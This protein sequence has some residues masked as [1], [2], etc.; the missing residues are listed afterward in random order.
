[1]GAETP[2][3]E[4]ALLLLKELCLLARGHASQVLDCGPPATMFMVEVLSDTLRDNVELFRARA[5]FLEV[6]REDV[7]GVLHHIL[8]T[9][10]EAEPETVNV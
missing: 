3:T 10:Q 2:R 5:P 8:K 1:M 7:C 6:L 9:Q 4:L